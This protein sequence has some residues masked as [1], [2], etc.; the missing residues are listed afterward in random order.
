MT[1]AR[2][3]IERVARASYGRLL[4]LIAARSRDIAA[5]EDALADA[6][7]IA[8][9]SWPS[10][11]VPTNPEAW[12]LTAAHNNLRH[13]WRRRK[14]QQS[15][16]E[17]IALLYEEMRT[18]TPSLF[19][20]ERLKLLFACAHPAI[21][22]AVRTP[23]ILQTVLGLDAA[24]I[25]S[26][27]LV[28]PAAMGQ[29]LVRAKSKIRDAGIA[30]GVPER[31][32]LPERLDAVLCAV[33]AAYGTGW[34]DALGAVAGNRDLG[35]EALA[36]GRMIVA[37]MPEEPEARGLLAL[38]LHC[39]A[40]RPARRSADGAFVPLDE[41]D[42]AL[43][44]RPMLSEAEGELTRAAQAGSAGRFQ[45]EAAIQSLHAQRRLLGAK[46]SGALVHLYDRL[47]AHSPTIG[48]LVARAAAYADADDVATGLA[49]LDALPAASVA[50][51]QPFWATRAVLLARSGDRQAA[52]AA[53]DRAI[54]LTEETAVH[55]FLS[56][57]RDSLRS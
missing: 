25:A 27:F 9:E 51:Y 45:L 21:E 53:Y 28:A 3:T 41:Q 55:R 47:V 8:V 37:L 40:R 18:M 23:L 13:V 30:F 10:R 29:R 54:G 56:D 2:R 7:R 44:S 35:D 43:W 6:F 36:L 5:A 34:D 11:G 32:E 42:T 12:L 38:M 14:T 24:R 46:P 1:E 50:S 15:A 22:E 48:A 31:S 20:D 16:A 4:A 19:P 33:Y 52:V 39:E 49:Q 17:T 57:R 26:A